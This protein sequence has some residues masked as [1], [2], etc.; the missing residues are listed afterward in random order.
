M[1][2]SLDSMETACLVY[3]L[4]GRNKADFMLKYTLQCNI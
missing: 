2:Y 1:M 3:N 4:E